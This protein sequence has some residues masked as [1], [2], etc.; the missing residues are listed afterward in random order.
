M[1]K[2]FDRRLKYLSDNFQFDPL[3]SFDQASLRLQEVMKG[4]EVTVMF[5]L[6]S[7][8]TSSLTRGNKIGPKD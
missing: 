1:V 4:G 2:A 3:S 7:N 6:L 5:I 8:V